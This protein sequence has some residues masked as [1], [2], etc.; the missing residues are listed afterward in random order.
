MNGRSQDGFWSVHWSK[1]QQKGRPVEIGTDSNI[2][3]YNSR[4]RKEEILECAYQVTGVEASRRQGHQHPAFRLTLHGRVVGQLLAQLTVHFIPET[5]SLTSQNKELGPGSS[6]LTSSRTLFLCHS[7]ENGQ[8]D[9]PQVFAKNAV[10]NNVMR[11]VQLAGRDVFGHGRQ[12]A[13]MLVFSTAR[14]TGKYHWKHGRQRQ[15]EVCD[16]ELE[17]VRTQ[18]DKQ[19]VHSVR[20]FLRFCCTSGCLKR[21]LYM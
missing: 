6:A 9:A 5:Q 17:V 10:T 8:V 16:F 12:A 13:G 20:A 1:Q 14:K 18:V 11:E 4:T 15:K 7:K 3:P 2:P 21:D 19:A